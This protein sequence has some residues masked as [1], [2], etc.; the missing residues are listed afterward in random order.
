MK[1]L[2]LMMV[3]CALP[4][5]AVL[6]AVETYVGHEVQYELLADSLLHVHSDTDHQHDQAS[7][8]NTCDGDHHHCHAH[9]IS[10]LPGALVFHFPAQAIDR[11]NERSTG[12]QSFYSDQIERP[13]WV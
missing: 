9:T 8:D 1:K 2:F 12:F 5:Q 7:S 13:K 10:V 3:M 4:L 6:A 11:L